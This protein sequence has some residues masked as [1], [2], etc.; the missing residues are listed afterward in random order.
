MN[1]SEFKKQHKELMIRHDIVFVQNCDYTPCVTGF[2]YY[3]KENES[4]S[5]YKR[6]VTHIT[7]IHF[8]SDGQLDGH[9]SDYLKLLKNDL[10]E[11][12]T[13]N[14]LINNR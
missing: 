10:E 14:P 8:T 7:G 4:D 11:I 3:A 5:E 1:Q 12:I 13:P 2:M 6:F 9:F